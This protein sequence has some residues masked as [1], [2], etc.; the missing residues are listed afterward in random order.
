MVKLGDFTVTTEMQYVV[1]TTGN[2]ASA[3]LDSVWSQTHNGV[4]KASRTKPRMN[5]NHVRYVTVRSTDEKFRLAR[6]RFCVL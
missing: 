5:P 6:M 4:G 2:G 1:S 3:L